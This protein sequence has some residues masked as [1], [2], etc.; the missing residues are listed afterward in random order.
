M[1]Y[2]GYLLEAVGMLFKRSNKI[3]QSKME[4][5]LGPNSQVDLTP[6]AADGEMLPAY[7]EAGYTEQ[8]STT[9]VLAVCHSCE[10]TVLTKTKRKMGKATVQRLIASNAALPILGTCNSCEQ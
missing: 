1:L 3:D 10:Q 4:N 2:R 8:L 6:N 7:T 9:P 5:R